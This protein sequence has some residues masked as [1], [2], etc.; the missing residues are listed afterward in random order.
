MTPLVLVVALVDVHPPHGHELALRVRLQL[1]LE[2]GH[3]V[4]GEAV[5]RRLAQPDPID[6]RRVVERIGDDGVLLGQ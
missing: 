4:V 2:I 1:L 6:D 5:A 3:V